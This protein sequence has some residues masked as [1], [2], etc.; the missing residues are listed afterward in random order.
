MN[1]VHYAQFNAKNSLSIVQFAKIT[2]IRN[3][4]LI[5]AQIVVYF[6]CA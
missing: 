6:N 2:K 3:K 1:G 4:Y 5:F